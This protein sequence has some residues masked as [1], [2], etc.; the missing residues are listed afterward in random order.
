MEDNY[1]IEEHIHR[2]A[3]WTAGRAASVS[4]FSTKGITSFIER[5]D[6]RRELGKIRNHE[7]STKEYGA[8]FSM[9]ADNIHKLTRFLEEYLSVYRQ[10]W[11][12]YIFKDC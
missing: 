10:K 5:I 12:A 7:I 11:L 4:R 6:L 1:C 3:C 9:Q 8:W 2:Y